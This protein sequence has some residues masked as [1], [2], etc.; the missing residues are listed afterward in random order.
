MKT[1]ISIEIKIEDLYKNGLE[2]NVGEAIYK[3]RYKITKDTY[4]MV[5]HHIE[6]S[7][8]EYVKYGGKAG[9]KRLYT[10]EGQWATTWIKDCYILRN[11]TI[12]S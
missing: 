8:D 12:D 3:R 2:P 9:E 6:E 7:A 10:S 1:T 4:K 5:T 11:V